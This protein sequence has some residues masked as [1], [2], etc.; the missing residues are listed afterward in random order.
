MESVSTAHRSEPRESLPLANRSP[1]TTNNKSKQQ[2]VN[3]K[4]T[5]EQYAANTKIKTAGKRPTPTPT[6]GSKVR[7]LNL[8]TF[9]RSEAYGVA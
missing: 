7:N 3:V 9:W 8:R 2:K 1:G 6:I 4:F 5:E